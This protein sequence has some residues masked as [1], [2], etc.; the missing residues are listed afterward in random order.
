MDLKDALHGS[1]R[2]PK[3]QIIMSKDPMALRHAIS[4]QYTEMVQKHPELDFGITVDPKSDDI[5]VHW[6][7]K[8]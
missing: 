4:E 2:V 7:R 6:S 5:V 8:D 1:V 3:S